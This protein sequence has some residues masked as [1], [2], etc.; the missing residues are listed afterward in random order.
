MQSDREFPKSEAKIR[1]A[2]VFTLLAIY[3][4]VMI[5]GKVISFFTLAHI[6]SLLVCTMPIKWQLSRNDFLPRGQVKF[7]TAL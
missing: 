3:I 4:F 1:L 7:D 2:F 6:V 5:Y